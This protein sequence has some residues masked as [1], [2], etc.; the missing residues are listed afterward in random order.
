MMGLALRQY[1]ICGKRNCDQKHN[2]TSFRQIVSLIPQQT[3]ASGP[4]TGPCQLATKIVKMIE[5]AKSSHQKRVNHTPQP[6]GWPGY[7]SAFLTGFEDKM[8]PG[9]ENGGKIGEEGELAV[10]RGP[11]TRDY[12]ITSSADVQTPAGRER[13]PEGAPSP[14]PGWMKYEEAWELIVGRK[15]R[16]P[17][18]GFFRNIIMRHHPADHKE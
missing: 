17:G 13:E 5:K 14:L 7:P 18:A 15:S 2:R 3:A 6:T 9:I 16:C 4:I 12:N 1:K 8:P 10:L 11:A